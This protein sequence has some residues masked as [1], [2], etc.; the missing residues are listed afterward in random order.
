MWPSKSYRITWRHCCEELH[1]WLERS[2][3][4]LGGEL[5][6]GKEYQGGKNTY[7][8]ATLS[9]SST[10]FG[11][12]Q[13]GM[14]N[15]L[16]KHTSSTCWNRDRTE[17]RWIMGLVA[18]REMTPSR[19]L[20]ITIS[21]SPSDPCFSKCLWMIQMKGRSVLQKFQDSFLQNSR[22]GKEFCCHHET[23]LICAFSTSTKTRKLWMLA[24]M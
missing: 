24:N 15:S 22:R 20:Y 6:L 11:A 23:S 14:W 4:V 8:N 5:E 17:R 7:L 1:W 18:V 21:D 9:R 19:P 3:W 10:E 2:F 12:A 13:D 16:W